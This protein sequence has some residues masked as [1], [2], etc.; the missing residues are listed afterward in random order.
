MFA[1]PIGTG[2]SDSRVSVALYACISDGRTPEA[3]LAALREYATAQQ[4]TVTAALYDIG[5][6]D[7]AKDE[8]PGLVRVLRLME[9][10]R[11]SGVVTPSP[12][13]LAVALPLRSRASAAF[14]RYLH[15]VEG[16]AEVVS[17]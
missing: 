13:H 8:R 10:G 1:I 16:A 12:D 6:L 9:D 4:W 2:R 3:V 5:P 7:R 15:A 11:V 14:I 17:P